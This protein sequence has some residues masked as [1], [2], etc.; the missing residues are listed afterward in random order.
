MRQMFFQMRMKDS[1]GVA[2]CGGNPT[3]VLAVGLVCLNT[4]ARVGPVVRSYGLV[5]SVSG[6]SC[7]PLLAK[8]ST[9][10]G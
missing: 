5:S 3:C 9:P 2:P 4:W 6:F 7:P 10:D 8:A 1:R